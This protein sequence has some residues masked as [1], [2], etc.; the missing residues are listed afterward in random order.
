MSN[1]AID[2]LSIIIPL[3]N[4]ERLITHLLDKLIA[5]A[6]PIPYEIIIVNDGS[7]DNSYKVCQDWIAQHNDIEIILLSKENGGKGSAFRKGVQFSKGTIVINQDSDLEYNPEDIITCI[8]PILNQ[9]VKVVYGSRELGKREVRPNIFF[10]FGGYA[11]TLATNILYFTWLTDEP[12]CYKTFDGDLIRALEYQGNHFEWEPEV[13][14]KLLRLGY[15]IKE[16][17]IHYHPRNVSEGK[18]IKFHDGV[19]ALWTLLKWRFIPIS[20]L[21]EVF[22]SFPR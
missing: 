17:P 10:L 19:S 21:K 13:T 20:K 14:A 4:E 6:F 7:K 3:Y 22:Q 11:V 8:T 15:K 5:V 1:N 18:K 16:V 9:E 12:T 2:K